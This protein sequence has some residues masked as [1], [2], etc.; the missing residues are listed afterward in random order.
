MTQPVLAIL[1]LGK[2]GPE[3]WDLQHLLKVR[4]GAPR[5]VANGFF[6]EFTLEAVRNFQRRKSLTVDGTVGF[7]TWTALSDKDKWPLICP[8]VFL[9]PALFPG[10]Q[11]KMGDKRLSPTV[12]QVVTKLQDCLQSPAS[13][14]PFYDGGING[15]FDEETVKAIKKFQQNAQSLKSNNDGV[16]GATTFT[17]ITALK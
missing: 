1:K 14:S 4:G 7:N 10:A 16:V 15:R 5:L 11:W 8:G 2:S 17:Y 9:K 12:K 13:G 6:D 3:V